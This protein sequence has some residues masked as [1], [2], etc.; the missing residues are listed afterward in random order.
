MTIR[1]L[2]TAGLGSPKLPGALRALT[3]LRILC[4]AGLGSPELPGALK[5]VVRLRWRR[6]LPAV[7]RRI[8]GWQELGELRALLDSA[9]P[10]AGR[11]EAQCIVGLGISKTPGALRALALPPGG[12][13][14]FRP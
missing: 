10:T 1:F 14:C 4:A 6:L 5:G 3:L 9:A 7:G 8:C 11:G 12:A 2:G 13:H